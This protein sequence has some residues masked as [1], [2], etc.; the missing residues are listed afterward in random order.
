MKHTVKVGDRF[1]L[2]AWEWRVATKGGTRFSATRKSS[3]GEEHS[4][5]FL[6]EE[7][8]QLVWLKREP[9]FTKEQVLAVK[10]WWKLN[11]KN[12]EHNDYFA[13]LDAH[14]AKE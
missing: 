11:H 5:V 8:D 13:W 2:G 10:N 7:A 6:D 12:F 3:D 9:T 14:I 4:T 1:L